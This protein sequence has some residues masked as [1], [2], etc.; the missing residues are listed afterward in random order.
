MRKM[1]FVEGGSNRE[2]EGE[3]VEEQT[4]K[5]TRGAKEGSQKS[6]R[7]LDSEPCYGESPA[8]LGPC[9]SMHAHA[10]CTHS[11]RRT[12]LASL[13]SNVGEQ[14]TV[15]GF[16]SMYRVRTERYSNRA[17]R[18]LCRD[19]L[20]AHKKAPPFQWFGCLW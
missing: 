14:G 8:K 3:V 11:V 5:R 2:R 15:L 20:F 7:C 10:L 13:F 18:Y 19:E 16:S 9:Q 17:G 6:F 4:A 1:Y 12:W